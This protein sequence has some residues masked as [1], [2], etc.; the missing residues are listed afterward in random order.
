MV[1]TSESKENGRDVLQENK[2]LRDV[3]FRNTII[4]IARARKRFYERI[5]E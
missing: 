1:L 5:L 2:A 3:S 4:N